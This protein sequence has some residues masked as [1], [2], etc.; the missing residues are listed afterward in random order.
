MN[1]G[2]AVPTG[3]RTK[4][5]ADTRFGLL[6]DNGIRDPQRW[7]EAIAVQREAMITARRRGV[8]LCLPHRCRQKSGVGSQHGGGRQPLA[9]LG[10]WGN[11]PLRARQQR[12]QR[13]T[14]DLC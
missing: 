8:C 11:G 12:K 14:L 10:D 2:R 5:G 7:L 3:K 1:G 9:P 13:K 4:E 6:W